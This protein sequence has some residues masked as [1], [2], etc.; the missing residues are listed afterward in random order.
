MVAIGFRR[1]ARGKLRF[2]STLGGKVVGLDALDHNS[3]WVWWYEFA[4]GLCGCEVFRWGS[5]DGDVMRSRN[6]A[7]SGLDYD[8][9]GQRA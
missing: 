7:T 5:V 1:I 4:F 2:A 3:C 9:E 6:D 8:L